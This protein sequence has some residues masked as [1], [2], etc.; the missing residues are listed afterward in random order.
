LAW[1]ANRYEE[2]LGWYD[3]AIQVGPG[4]GLDWLKI[5]QNC[6]RSPTALEST[7][8]NLFLARNDDNWFIDTDFTLESIVPWRFAY[9]EQA[10][11]DVVDCPGVPG[12][13]CAHIRVGDMHLESGASWHQCIRLQPDKKYRFS[14]WLRVET[15]K[16]GKWRPLYYQGKIDGRWYGDWLGDQYGVTDWAYYEQVFTA[17]EFETNYACFHPVR[18]HD[19]GEIWFYDPKL[20]VSND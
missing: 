1:R 5:G 20:V 3:W 13:K 9:S 10:L 12:Q 15:H 7:V 8:C 4:E 6:Q 17:P 16:R 11:H 14:V 18:L 2:A 19:D